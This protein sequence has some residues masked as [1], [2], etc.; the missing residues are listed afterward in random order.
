[1]VWIVNKQADSCLQCCRLPRLVLP[2]HFT[3][4]SVTF[5]HLSPPVH[6]FVTLHDGIVKAEQLSCA[7]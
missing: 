2:V 5:L 6:A 1:M 3:N 7:G 4:I